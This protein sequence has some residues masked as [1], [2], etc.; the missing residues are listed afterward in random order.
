MRAERLQLISERRGQNTEA[1]EKLLSGELHLDLGLDLAQVWRVSWRETSR[2]TSSGD[3][4]RQPADD[5]QGASAQRRR[6][7]HGRLRGNQQSPR[8]DWDV[9]LR[10]IDEL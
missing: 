8:L 9:P 2:V 5:R 7:G 3:E 10:D 1:P 4:V 6:C